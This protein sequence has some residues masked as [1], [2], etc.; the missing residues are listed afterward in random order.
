MPLFLYGVISDTALGLLSLSLAVIVLVPGLWFARKQWKRLLLDLE[1]QTA[2]EFQQ[3]VVME[4]ARGGDTPPPE[5]RDG[6]LES[7][8]SEMDIAV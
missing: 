6:P 7:S 2:H 8:D 5:R 4:H 1:Y 3:E